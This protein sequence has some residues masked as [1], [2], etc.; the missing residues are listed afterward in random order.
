MQDNKEKFIK[1]V[2]KIIKN[3]RKKLGKSIY[4]IS[5][6]SDILNSTWRKAE[7]GIYKDI[8][9][10]T[11]WKMLE[12]LEFPPDEFMLELKNNLGCDFSFL[13]N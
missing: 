2:C 6:E 11:L 3:R 9:L 13:D 7:S 5:A 4:Q 1:S 8:K 10:I 12:G